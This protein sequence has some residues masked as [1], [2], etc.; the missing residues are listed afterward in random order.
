MVRNLNPQSGM[1]DRYVGALRALSLA[2]FARVEEKHRSCNDP[3]W[4]PDIFSSSTSQLMLQWIIS[5]LGIVS[6]SYHGGSL[7]STEAQRAS[8]G[9][10][11]IYAIPTFSFQGSLT[12]QFSLTEV[13]KR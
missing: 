10:L 4:V 6:P 12:S 5:L 1:P 11:L 2:V 3:V 9:T 8:S 7:A 13:F